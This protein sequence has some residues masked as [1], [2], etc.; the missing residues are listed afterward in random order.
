MI[1]VAVAP[2]PQ[3]A[4][5]LHDYSAYFAMPLWSFVAN[6]FD[7]ELD[8]VPAVAVLQVVAVIAVEPFVVG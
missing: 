2:Q 1:A 6:H 3:I 7:P 8:W 5:S 4:D